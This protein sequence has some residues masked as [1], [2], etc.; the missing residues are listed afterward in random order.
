M[1]IKSL[2]FLLTYQCNFA[3]DH[4]FVW[5]G[6]KAEG[7]MTLDDIR[8]IYREGRK[9][10]T[11]RRIYFEGGE[12][13]LY[14]PIMIEGLREA[15]QMGF[16]TGIVTNGYW[17][18]TPEDAIEWLKPIAEAGIDDLTVSDD[19]LH[20]RK[21]DNRAKNAIGAA[22]ELGLPIGTIAIEE[23]EKYFKEIERGEKPAAGAVMF[24]GRAAEK[25]LGNLPRKSWKEFQK[26]VDENFLSQSR[27]HLDPLGYVH[28]CQ[29]IAMGNFKREPLSK[30]IEDFDPLTH[31]ICG[32]ILDRGPVGL[33][34]A[35]GA[36]HE[37]AYVDECHLCYSVRL[38]LRK[39]FPECLVPDQMYGVCPQS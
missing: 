27:V 20:Y 32:P 13:F 28:L 38:A 22:K 21:G 25:L 30:L 33:A 24:R 5:G 19:S 7:V 9:L 3:C 16:E 15:K 6:P 1:N 23:P 39:R 37:E 12:P 17:A 29:G 4:C 31:P 34:E 10:G 8:G 36:P 14:F 11:V 35:Y 18:T 2:H 26:C